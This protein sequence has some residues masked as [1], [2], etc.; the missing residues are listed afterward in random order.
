MKDNDRNKIDIK[1]SESGREDEEAIIE[2]REYL[3]ETNRDGG[4][5][6]SRDS[7]GDE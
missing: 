2:D 4:G 3:S 5:A 7:E 6:R 1:N